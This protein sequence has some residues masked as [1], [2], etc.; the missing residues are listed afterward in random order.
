MTSLNLS[1]IARGVPDVELLRALAATNRS[2][3]ERMINI[4]I[5]ILDQTDADPDL[6]PE[7]DGACDEEEISTGFH[8][9]RNMPGPGCPIADEDSAEEYRPLWQTPEGREFANARR[10]SLGMLPI[11]R[12]R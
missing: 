8:A 11:A 3:L 1:S 10:A 2:A 9:L 7:E 6:E 5:D 12:R 4:A